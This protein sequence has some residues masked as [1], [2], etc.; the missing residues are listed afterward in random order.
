[1]PVDQ[2]AISQLSIPSDTVTSNSQ[3]VSG[4]DP[5][6]GWKNKLSEQQVSNIFKVLKIFNMD[7]YNHELEPDYEKLASFG[8]HL[9]DG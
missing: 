6:S 2:K 8:Q 1:M 3:I 7:F 9:K 5:L 4:K